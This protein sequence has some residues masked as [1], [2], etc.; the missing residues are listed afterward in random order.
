MHEVYQDPK[1]I[2]KCQIYIKCIKEHQM[3]Q[4]ASGVSR[5]IRCIK[6]LSN[7]LGVSNK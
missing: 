5:D 2:E 7:V 3:Y 1:V 4:G 6:C